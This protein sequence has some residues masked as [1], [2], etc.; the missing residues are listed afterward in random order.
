MYGAGGQ[1]RVPDQFIKDFQAKVN[2]RNFISVTG[3]T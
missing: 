3:T 2:L 1:K